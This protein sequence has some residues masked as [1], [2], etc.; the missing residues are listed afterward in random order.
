LISVS[1]Y[2]C[3]LWRNP[4]GRWQ[5]LERLRCKRQAKSQNQPVLWVLKM[6]EINETCSSKKLSQPL[7]RRIQKGRLDETPSPTDNDF[8]ILHKI[9]I[10]PEKYL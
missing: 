8:Q 5:L 3:R 4:R 7:Q 6:S 2:F 9:R 1:G 10:N